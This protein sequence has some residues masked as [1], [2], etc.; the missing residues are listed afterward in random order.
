M[1]KQPA[2]KYKGANDDDEEE[3]DFYYHCDKCSQKFDDWKE[4]QKHKLDCVKVPRKFACSKCNRGFQQKK[5]DGTAFRLL[6]H[7]KT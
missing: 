6:P 3:D 1:N 4:L 7:Q 2:S 5:N